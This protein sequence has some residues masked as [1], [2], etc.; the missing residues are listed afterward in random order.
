MHYCRSE[1]S[2]YLLSKGESFSCWFDA[3]NKSRQQEGRI[4]QAQTGSKDKRSNFR[5]NNLRQFHTTVGNVGFQGR[6]DTKWAP[7]TSC[8]CVY[9]SSRKGQAVVQIK[10]NTS[11]ST[12]G[13]LSRPV[14]PP[15]AGCGH[16][17]Q[18]QNSVTRKNNGCLRVQESHL[19]KKL[20]SFVSSSLCAKKL[21]MLEIYGGSGETQR[22]PGGGVENRQRLPMTPMTVF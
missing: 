2:G 15:V 14:V 5:P 4:K 22:N 11:A 1:A 12:C 20:K 9:D 7:H 19:C 10:T 8:R 18:V 3:S 17:T 16:L 6:Q 13:T 21:R